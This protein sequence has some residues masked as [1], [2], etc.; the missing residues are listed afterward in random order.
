MREGVW[1]FV[2][3]R[4]V[5]GEQLMLA[6]EQR[7]AYRLQL[8][9]LQANHIRLQHACSRILSA[10][11]QAGIPTICMR[12]LAVI[13][14]YYGDQGALRPVSDID[15]LIDRERMLDAKQ[16]LWDIGFRPDHAYRNIY[17]RGDLT[18]DL[19]YEPIGIERIRSWQHITSLRTSDFFECAE[20]GTLA[21]AEALLLKPSV[22][23]PYLCFHA[24]KH[25]FERLIWLYDIALMARSVDCEG[26]WDNVLK[27]IREHGLERPCFYALSYVKE[28]LC[29]PVPDIVLESIRPEMSRVERGLFRRHMAHE[30]IPYLAERLFARMQPDFRH[31]IEFWR[32]TIY[33]RY[34]IRQQI[35][36]TGCVRCNFI[37]K[38]LKQ[39]LK[40][41]WQFVREGVALARF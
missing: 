32:E 3:E 17:M 25:S 38:R 37:R 28:H 13:E 7:Q 10:L 26:K 4:I 9:E 20:A 40:G 24:L 21:S 16:V 14:R 6:D 2:L 34:E 1:G 31:R 33:P 23:L 15:L 19:H 11:A 36:G 41:V 12:G 5:S 35:A 39:L 18:V 27:G 29:A 8:R 22:E 30:V